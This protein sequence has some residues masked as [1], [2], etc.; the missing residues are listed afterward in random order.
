[1]QQLVDKVAQGRAE[2]L[3]FSI[4]KTA[5]VLRHYHRGGLVA[6][7]SSDRYLW[8]GLKQTRA[9]RELAILLSLARKNLP[10]PKPFAAR[11]IHSGCYYRAD[12]ITH[13]LADTETLSQRLRHNVIDTAVW[14]EIG[15][16]IARF[17][18]AGVYHADLNAHNIMLNG[19][20]EVF[21]ID[22]DKAQLKN[23][24][25]PSWRRE[26]LQRLHRSLNKLSNDSNVFYFNERDWV[27]L[28]QGYFF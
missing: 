8:L 1:M 12:I 23:P 20:N 18:R 17:H 3:F 9:Y 15:S 16:T 6:K 27:D 5:L 4:D 19:H 22:F 14:R 26:N 11:I 10:A 13:T 7:L 24:G 2:T 25:Q 21:I 28:E